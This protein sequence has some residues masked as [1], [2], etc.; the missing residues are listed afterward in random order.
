MIAFREVV[1]R[2]LD[3]PITSEKEF[4]LK[5]FVPTARRLAKKYDIKYDPETPVPADDDLAD[6]L[7]QAGVEFF[8]TVG[9]YCPDTERRIT[10]TP[11]EVAFALAYDRGPIVF[12]DGVDRRVFP[13]RQPEDSTP[14]WCSL[15]A[16]G[17]AVSSEFHLLSLIREY[18]RNPLC[19]SITTPSLTHA[20]GQIIIAGSPLEVEGAIRNMVLAREALRQAGRPG[21]PIVN[22]VASAAHA[23]SHIAGS[24]FGIGPTDA[25]EI[26]AHHEMRVDFDSMNKVAYT[27]SRGAQ[28][29]AENGVILGGIAGGPATTAI[30]TAAY[31]LLDMFVLRGSTQHP[32][33]IH[34]D[35]RTT[36][37]RDT[38]W[39]R[40][41]S[42]QAIARHSWLPVANLGYVGAG[43]MTKMA[44]YE[45]AAWVTAAIV[46]GGSIEAEGVAKN[47][48][49][50]HTS[51]I[52]PYF[53]SEVAHAVARMDRQEANHLVKALL[54]QYEEHLADAP[55]GVRMQDCMDLESGEIIPEFRE[56]Y[57]STRQEMTEKF[58]LKFKY[59]SIYL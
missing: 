42:N 50:D 16:G 39:V 59:P 10:F 31:N 26:G 48:H 21:L 55:V 3:G 7:W 53:A 46:S 14:P 52:E 17:G 12:G 36:T 47:A 20:D 32:F 28:I 22:G 5:L 37:A 15:G 27:L 34:F 13:R 23:S 51:P 41:V 56:L 11:E 9:V 49:V 30:V 43:P 2:A 8:L 4:D 35:L 33:P 54:K 18:A 38:L 25:M 24:G 19:W 29:W 1:N 44:L 40:S 57:R 58:G 45:T 6:R